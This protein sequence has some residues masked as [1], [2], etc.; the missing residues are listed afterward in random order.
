MQPGQDLVWSDVQPRETSDQKQNA[1]VDGHLRLPTD[2]SLALPR[3]GLRTSPWRAAR[4]VIP[5]MVAL[6]CSAVAGPIAA[7]PAGE[8]GSPG[9]G[10]EDAA[11]PP[12]PERAPSESLPSGEGPGAAPGEAPHQAPAVD[13]TTPGEVP[14]T[15]KRPPSSEAE[16]LTEKEIHDALERWLA[17]L[18]RPPQP[19]ARLVRLEDVLAADGTTS[20][21][22]A[23]VKRYWRAVIAI[24]RAQSADAHAQKIR[25]FTAAP[26]DQAL[27]SA[28]TA[29]AEAR[30]SLLATEATR[31]RRKLTSGF[32]QALAN[33]WP[34]ELPHVGDYASHFERMLESGLASPDLR[35]LADML[36]LDHQRILLRQRS[37][38]AAAEYLQAAATAYRNQSTD[39]GTVVAAWRDVCREEGALLTAIEDYNEHIAEYA[40]EVAPPGIT[41]ERL[42][43]MLIRRDAG[44]GSDSES[45]DA[46]STNG[47][48]QASAKQPASGTSGAA[49]Q[50]NDG[51]EESSGWRLSREPR[52][53]DSATGGPS[54]PVP[55]E[56]DD[57]SEN[58]QLPGDPA[59]ATPFENHT[60]QPSVSADPNEAPAETS[61]EGGVTAATGWR[62]VDRST[63]ASGS[64]WGG[65]AAAIYEPP[66]RPVEG[67]TATGEHTVYRTNTAQPV[68]LSPLFIPDNQ[69]SLNGGKLAAA[70]FGDS[71]AEVV[72]EAWPLSRC[73]Q[74]VSSEQRPELLRRYWEAARSK[75]RYTLLVKKSAALAE[76]RAALADTADSGSLAPAQLRAAEAATDAQLQDARA[77]L[78]EASERLTTL[79]AADAV[80]GRIIPADVPWTGRYAVR[81]DEMPTDLQSAPDVQAAADMIERLQATVGRYQSALEHAQRAYRDHAGSA[82]GLTTA[83][84]LTCL[85][86]GF[87]AAEDWTEAVFAYNRQIAEYAVAVAPSDLAADRFTAMLIPADRP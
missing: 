36:P 62:G 20:D 66:V 57:S 70:I 29:T 73:L 30:A 31:L 78:T 15:S 32:S 40:L 35:I 54:P 16:P 33:G 81:L 38:S 69:E 5:L 49:G 55:E 26:K 67:G 71:V 77:V 64:G 68:E 48:G 87:H 3:S 18:A 86:V 84:A 19:T 37:L 82:A 10:G 25:A 28:F 23:G 52:G 21:R 80:N 45:P 50:P 12:V 58:G 1:R 42:V 65:V 8:L 2:W 56:S 74:R 61:A 46:E 17:Q 39:V 27:W 44:A 72:G 85:D 6:L 22:I 11:E 9:N 4:C 83:G 53:S 41:L 24:C 79:V 51:S 14:P 7:Q 75:A 43:R 76:L 34:A 13:D 60:R 59:E 63:A 47:A